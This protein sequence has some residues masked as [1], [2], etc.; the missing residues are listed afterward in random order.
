M[1]D[2]ASREGAIW[3][4]GQLV[5]WRSAQTHIMNQG[6]NYGLTVIEGE[7]TYAGRIFRLREHTERLIASAKAMGFDIPWSRGEIELATMQIIKESGLR[8]GFVRALAWPG[9]KHMDLLPRDNDVNLAIAVYGLT[10]GPD[11]ATRARGLRVTL[12]PARR[13]YPDALPG[14]AKSGASWAIGSISRQR[15]VRA[16]FDDAIMLDCDGGLAGTT[17]ANIFLGMGDHV[18]T[19]LPIGYCAGITRRTAIE[20][21]KDRGIAVVERAV[22][23]G[24]LKQAREVFIT[25]TAA[26]ITP[27][28]RIDD[29]N[30]PI[31]PHCQ[32]VMKDY[33]DLVH[34]AGELIN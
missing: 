6:L 3:L 22:S 8:Y 5:P 19:P 31:G 29:R 32:L 17:G 20:L 34:V 24:E 18:V 7:R 26:E 21:L 23:A 13:P 33:Q 12:T 30:L 1:D 28:T 10:A 15:A 16:G 9:S 14:F 2:F 25:G 4:N 27:I 11:E